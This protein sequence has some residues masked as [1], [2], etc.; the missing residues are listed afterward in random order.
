M[1]PRQIFRQRA[2]RLQALFVLQDFL[3]TVAMHL[4]P[5]LRGHNGHGID[6]EILEQAVIAGACAA[7]TAGYDRRARLALELAR[8]TVKQAVEEGRAL[9]ARSGIVDRRTDDQRVKLVQPRSKRIHAVV[10]NAAIS[11]PAFAAADAACNG[12]R[13]DLIDLGFNAVLVQLLFHLVQRRIG[14]ARAMR[15]AVKE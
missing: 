2:H 4:I 14:A 11:V 3:R 5:I 6:A 8:R 15:A 7:A 13:A 12:L 9:S 1:Q 10:K